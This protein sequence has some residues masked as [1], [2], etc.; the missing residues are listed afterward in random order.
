MTGEEGHETAAE[1]S[2]LVRINCMFNCV[3]IHIPDA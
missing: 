1:H 3:D 2:I